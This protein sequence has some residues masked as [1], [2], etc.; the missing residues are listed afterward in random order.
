MDREIVI[1]VGVLAERRKA[2]SQWADDIWRPVAVLIGE[3]QFEPGSV[4]FHE[5]DFTRFFV[6]HADIDLHATETD[7]YVHNLESAEPVLY[8]VLRSDD[9]GPLPYYVH[10]VTAS[11]YLALDIEDTAEDIVERVAMPHAVLR[12]VADFVDAHHVE[13]AFTKRKRQEIR[14]EEHKFGKE[15]VFDQSPSRRSNGR[16]H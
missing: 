2:V 9:G 12:L 14:L 16:E 15:P 5:A 13:R 3:T 8:V 4:V 7:A 1:N 11:P 10:K 6:G